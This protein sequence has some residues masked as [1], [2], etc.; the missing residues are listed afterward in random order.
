MKKSPGFL[1]V[2]YKIENKCIKSVDFFDAICYNIKDQTYR[3]GGDRLNFAN[4]IQIQTA[5]LVLCI[6]NLLF[7]LFQRRTD[8]MQNKL[9]I[10]ANGILFLNAASQ[11]A[12]AA[13][14]PMKHHS[15]GAF[16][17]LQIV[18]YSYFAF[19]TLLAPVFAIYVNGVAGNQ[20][21]I[22]L[23]EHFKYGGIC[24]LTEAFVLT[25][26]IHHW[27][28]HFDQNLDFCRGWAEHIIYLAA[29]FYCV[30]TIV[31][32][33]RAWRAFTRKRRGALIYFFAVTIMGVLAQFLFFEI[34]TELF[35]EALGLMGVMIAIEM[36][37]DRIDI[38][39]G[40]YNRKALQNDIESFL[41]HRRRFSVICLKI[42]NA[43]I[44]QRATGS[45]NTDIL[46]HI[47]GD[48]LKSVVPRYQIY[49][50]TNESFLLVLPDDEEKTAVPVAQSIVERFESP[51]RFKD[52]DIPFNA[53][54]LTA[55]VPGRLHSAQ[56]VLAMADQ[57]LPKSNNKKLLTSED[58]DYLLRRVA[59]EEAVTRGLEEGGFE[60]YYQPT[61]YVD[62][63][64]H[65]AEALIRL[66]DSVIGSVFPD[67]FI[68]V[69]EQIGMIDDLDNFV[70][71]EVCRFIKGGI[72]DKYHMDC[73]NVNLSVLHCMQPGFVSQIN[74]IAEEIGIDKHKINFEITESVAASDY[75]MLSN[76]VTSLKREGYHFSMDDYGTGYS[77]MESIFSLDF[78]VVKID[79]SILW[80]AEKSEVGRIV[81]ENTVHMVRQMH[82]EILVEGV[83]TQAQ[84]DLLSKL[85]VDYLQGYF[86]SRPIPKD[87]FVRYLSEYEQKRAEL[88]QQK[89]ELER[90]KAELEQQNAASSPK[91]EES[92]PKAKRPKPKKKRA[93]QKHNK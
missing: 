14:E 85:G 43:E 69:A 34:K 64:L 88:E 68:P 12:A 42:L 67:E 17:A 91:A 23:S 4:D 73:I 41:I 71:A 70:F 7:T 26:P 89:A 1:F 11:I 51:F 65:G 72:P 60:V 2:L 45:M 39:T 81:L 87:A 30:Y 62:G 93:K 86:F 18:E 47:L 32:L 50:T 52:T 3:K 13:L 48:Y 49:A 19:H 8:K 79:K 44:V 63:R 61:H 83:E 33:I 78:D 90:Q 31:L 28:Y 5:A 80:S 20:R 35:A 24:F 59:V 82:R 92:R 84:I 6:T 10:A 36:E 74:Q 56:D 25:N 46:S 75:G 37:D 77:N 22:R 57:P 66:H 58:L 15:Q 54:V 21:R 29:L 16:L 55:D 53:A 27:V 38:D 76:I 9:Y 40:F